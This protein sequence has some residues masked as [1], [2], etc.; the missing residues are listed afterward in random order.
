MTIA[1]PTLMPLDP[2]WPAT[3]LY[4]GKPIALADVE[5][6]LDPSEWGNV[7]VTVRGERTRPWRALALPARDEAGGVLPPG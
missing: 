6:T 7:L 3:G 5:T 2:S 4:R 1:L